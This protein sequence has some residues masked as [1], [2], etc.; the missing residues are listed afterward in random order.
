MRLPLDKAENVLRLLLEGMSVRSV[1]RVTGVHRDTI[2]RLLLLAGERCQRLMDEKFKGLD[3]HDV[4]VDEI[5]GYVGKKEG[6][7]WAHEKEVTDIGDAYCFVA[8]ERDTKL[9]LAH[10]LGKRDALSTDKFICKLALA[11]SRQRYQL[12]SDGFK[13]Y[14]RPCRCSWRAGASSPNWSRSTAHRGKA[15]RVTAR[16]R[17]WTRCHISCLGTLTGAASALAM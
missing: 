10:H 4:Q 3:V 17:W 11:T 2:L 13:P 1:E 5:W 6:H 16:L 7:K 8:I 9:V 14:S 15:S 12:T